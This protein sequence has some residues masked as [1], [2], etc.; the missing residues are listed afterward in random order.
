MATL[1]RDGRQWI[2]AGSMELA[3]PGEPRAGGFR[4]FRRKSHPRP[5]INVIERSFFCLGEVLTK[6][7]RSYVSCSITGRVFPPLQST[8]ARSRLTS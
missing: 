6:I 3:G 5:M 7:V 2:P 4:G 1:E 8:E